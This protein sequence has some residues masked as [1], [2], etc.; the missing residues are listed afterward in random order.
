M[1][2][3]AANVTNQ[4]QNRA[5][6]DFSAGRWESTIDVRASHSMVASN[7]AITSSN[8]STSELTGSE[9]GAI[10]VPLISSRPPLMA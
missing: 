1:N 7:F 10:W 5:W 6:R 4:T 8:S 3:V 2:D 9:A